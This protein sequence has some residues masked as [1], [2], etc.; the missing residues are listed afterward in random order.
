MHQPRSGWRRWLI[1]LM[2]I[3]ALAAILFLISLLPVRLFNDPVSTVLVDRNGVLLGARVAEDGQWRFPSGPVPDKLKK[4][5]LAFEDRYFSFHPGVN[6]VSL[7]R[8]MA[9]NIRERRIVRG[10]STL[11]MQTIRLSR[12]EN[13]G[14]SKKNSWK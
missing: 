4:A 12:K 2:G 9:A 1:T 7:V 8:A 14:L 13:P 3:S 10:G 11:T 5:T 6:P